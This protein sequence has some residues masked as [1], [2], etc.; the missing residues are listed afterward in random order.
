MNEL[1][2]DC[3]RSLEPYRPGEQPSIAGLIKLNTNENPYPPSPA[4]LSALQSAANAD[5]RL[6]P[7]P[8]AE[9]LKR[10]IAE[11]HGVTEASIFVGNGSDEVLAHAFRALLKHDRPVLFPDV[12][13]GFYPVY[14]ALYGIE[15]EAVRWTM[16][17]RSTF[18][19]M[20][21]RTAA[22]CYPTPMRRPE[23]HSAFRRSDHCWSNVP[24]LSS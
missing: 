15:F 13:Y 12:T 18:P 19:T 24:V 6:Y 5:L 4:V 1:W 11:V 22:S 21:A 2:S 9:T 17:F 10:T 20:S 8:D 14:C 3:I 7:E 16:H 23:L